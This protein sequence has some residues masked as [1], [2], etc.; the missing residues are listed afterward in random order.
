MVV[1]GSAADLFATVYPATL[2]HELQHL[3]NFAH[4]CVQRPCE[5]PEETWINEALS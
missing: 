5:G 2:A 3:L 4:R 1:R